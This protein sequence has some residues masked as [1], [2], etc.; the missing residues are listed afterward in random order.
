MTNEEILGTFHRLT[1]FVRRHS[2]HRPPPPD[3]PSPESFQAL[4]ERGRILLLL[5][6]NDGLTHRR[7][8]ELLD[9]R[10]QSISRPL[11]KLEKEG[12][13]ERRENEQ[14]K[15]ESLVFLSQSWRTQLAE[16]KAEREQFAS[17]FLA[18]LTE[19]EREQL[20]VLLKKLLDAKKDQPL[21]APP[22]CGPDLSE[23]G[24]PK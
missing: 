6:K 10:P 18:P 24:G 5:E 13:V 16:I 4:R 11:A 20:G 21:C 1:G 8:A 19:E 2:H 12:V 3:H 15:R 14:D 9:V 7:L 23:Q 22:P 17:E